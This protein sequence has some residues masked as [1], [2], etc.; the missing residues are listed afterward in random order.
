[1][2]TL[3]RFLLSFITL[4]FSAVSVYSQCV[5]TNTSSNIATAGSLKF[6]INGCAAGGTITFNIPGAGPHT[7]PVIAGAWPDG[8]L[9]IDKQLHIQGPNLNGAEIIINGQ[10]TSDAFSV[11]WWDGAPAPGANGT[12]IEGLTIVNSLVG[13]SIGPVRTDNITIRNM[14]IGV[15]NDGTVVSNKEHGII[16]NGNPTD[17]TY[18]AF[19]GAPVNN[20]KIQN[21]VISGNEKN[22]IQFGFVSNAEVSGNKIGT[23]AAGTAC[24]V[25]VGTNVVNPPGGGNGYDGILFDQTINSVVKNNVISCNGYAT[26]PNDN[27]LINGT[28]A[29]YLGKRGIYFQNSDNNTIAGNMIGTNLAGEVKLPNYKSGILISSGSDNNIIGGITATDRNIISGNGIVGGTYAAVPDKHGIVID[30]GGLGAT[31]ATGSSTKNKIIGNYIGLSTSGLPL[32]NSKN[33]VEI[34]GNGSNNLIG[35]TT[36]D[37]I[38]VISGNG[39]N[40]VSI[41]QGASSNKITGNFIGTK[42]DGTAGGAT[43]GNGNVGV[44]L[45]TGTSTAA[46]SLK[47]LTNNTIQN[48]IIGQSKVGIQT[49]GE[50][51][52]NS[53]V[54]K[55][56]LIGSD[57]N[58]LSIPN[59]TNGILIQTELTGFQLGGVLVTESNI[60]VNSTQ[61]GINIA[62]PV[63]ST[64]GAVNA[65]YNNYIGVLKNG[66]VAKNGLSGIETN[67]KAYNIIIGGTATNQSN[68][69]AGNDK[70]GVYVGGGDKITIDKNFIGLLADGLTAKGNKG[71]GVQFDGTTNAIVQNAQIAFNGTGTS[72]DGILITGATST[73]TLDKNL[74]GT[75]TAMTTNQANL[76]FGIN[77]S[78]GVG[79]VSDNSIAYNKQGGINV[80]GA[81]GLLTI[82][83]NKIGTVT[84]S[85]P[86]TGITISGGSNNQLI[87]NTV[88]NHAVDGVSIS[89]TTVN[90]VSGN[91][92]QDNTVNGVSISGGTNTFNN[93][94][95]ANTVTANKGD[96][97]NI[98]GGT[99]TISS[100]N[101]TN[102]TLNGYSI[103]D[104]VNSIVSSTISGNTKNGIVL[105]GALGKT[106]IGAGTGNSISTN[107]ENGI[108]MTNGATGNKVDNNSAINGNGTAG[109]VGTGSGI[110][111]DNASDNVIGSVANNIKNNLVHGILVINGSANN[112]IMRSRLGGNAEQGIAIISAGAGNEITS[113]TIESSGKNGL[114]I[115]STSGTIVT[116][117]N[118]GTSVSGNTLDGINLNQASGNTFTSN[119]V[120]FNNAEGVTLNASSTNTFTSNTIGSNIS[121]GV[122]ITGASNTNTFESNNIG[123]TAAGADNSNG[124]NKAGIQVNGGTGN[125]IG[126]TGKPNVFGGTTQDYGVF[127]DGGT[128]TKIDFNYFGTKNAT[129][130]DVSTAV[131]AILVTGGTAKV[132]SINENVFSY[133]TKVAVSLESTSSATSIN[134]NYFGVDKDGTTLLA[135]GIPLTAIS[136]YKGITATAVTNNIIPSTTSDAIVI[137]GVSTGNTVTGNK[138]GVKGDNTAG[139][140]SAS[141]VGVKVIG[142]T[143]ALTV[144]A[145]IIGLYHDGINLTSGTSDATISGNFIG[146]NAALATVDLGNNTTGILID[147]T[148]SN[149]ILSSNTI[150][151]NAEG[152]NV[153][154]GSGNLISQNST[155]CNG[156]TTNYGNGTGISLTGGNNNFMSGLS[157]FK[158][159]IMTK[160]GVRTLII[161]NDSLTKYGLPTLVSG[162][163]VEIFEND[164]DCQNC[165]G[166]TYSQTI[167]F[168]ATSIEIPVTI[169]TTAD[170]KKYVFTVTDASNNTSP[171]SSCSFCGGCSQPTTVDLT[172]SPNDTVCDGGDI[173][174]AVAFTPTTGYGIAWYKDNVE[175]PAQVGLSTFDNITLTAG[176]NATY[177]VRIWDNA[178]PANKAD[179]ACY[180]EVDSTL[181][182]LTLPTASIASGPAVCSGDSATLNFTFTGISPFTFT[183]TDGTT[184]VT[185]SNY[186]T[187]TYSKKVAP[188]VGTTSYS[189]SAM[190]D[191]FCTATSL[192]SAATVTVNP[193]PVITVTEP[194]PTC[195]TAIA[196]PIA[197]AGQTYDYKTFDF[198]TV[199]TSPVT[200]SGSYQII[201]TII[202]TGCKDTASILASI[203]KNPLITTT[204]ISAVCAPLQIDLATGI[205]TTST[206]GG[207][208][209][210]T[211]QVDADSKTSAL[212]SSVVSEGATPTV[213]YFVRSE[214]IYTEAASS[215]VTSTTCFVTDD[216][217]VTIN[218]KPVMVGTPITGVC[219][220]GTIDLNLGIDPTTTAGLTYSYHKI[221]F[222]T[223]T[224]VVADSNSY[225]IIGI[226]V[227]SCRDTLDV[228]ADIFSL[229]FVTASSNSPVCVGDAINL[230]STSNVSATFAWT[231]PSSYTDATQNP[232]I[233]GATLAMDGVYTIEVTNSTTSCK[234]TATTTVAVKAKPTP[235]IT[236][237][238]NECFNA[239]PAARKMST[240]N[241]SGNTYTWVLTPVTGNA[242]IVGANNSNSIDLNYLGFGTVNVEV[243]EKVGSCSEVATAVLTIQ[244]T[245]RYSLS[246]PADCEYITNY[247][248]ASHTPSSISVAGATYSS[249]NGQFLKNGSPLSSPLDLSTLTVG[250]NKIEY[251]YTLGSA[252]NSCVSKVFADLVV[253]P[254]PA[255]LVFAPPTPIC[256]TVSPITLSGT[257][258]T[259]GITASYIG[260]GVIGDKFNPSGLGGT[261]STITYTAT[262][263]ATGCF[264]TKNATIAV[265]APGDPLLAISQDS[266]RCQ[267][268]A[269]LFTVKDLASVITT[270]DIV[271][272]RLNNPSSPAIHQGLTYTAAKPTEIN[273]NDVLYVKVVPSVGSCT[274]S[275]TKTLTAFTVKVPD[276]TDVI[277]DPLKVCLGEIFTLGASATNLETSFSFDWFK[278]DLES[279]DTV[280]LSGGQNITDEGEKV[281]AF[282]YFVK[283]SNFVSTSS[284]D[285]V[286]FTSDPTNI[287]QVV[288]ASI[289]AL[290]GPSKDALLPQGSRQVQGRPIILDARHPQD[291]QQ[292][293]N[294]SWTL[295]SV[296]DR[297]VNEGAGSTKQS[298]HTPT[299]QEGDK[300]LVY[301]VSANIKDLATCSASDTVSVRL[302]GNCFVP[303]GFSPNGDGANDTWNIHCLTDGDYPDAIV[304]IYNRWGELIYKDDRGGVIPWDGTRNGNLVPIGTYYFVIDLNFEDIEQIAGAVAIMR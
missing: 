301:K 46:G 199:V 298:S 287:V 191:K 54:V 197:P 71:N 218:P 91:T 170:C 100:T 286:C 92:I 52:V 184:P 129:L 108:L 125:I 51:K 40:G 200:D 240:P 246:L 261:S 55:G 53:F 126:T 172:V 247:D 167:T 39:E 235:V 244:D 173:D 80:S 128:G 141:G 268:D 205:N 58:G 280:T 15:Q 253:N 160:S 73:F 236:N 139:A 85:S 296:E 65:I 157:A 2:N 14:K 67:D 27:T 255:G 66:T 124:A 25:T 18:A 193:L 250:V 248:L 20:L 185:I 227:N 121:N 209:Y 277:I 56:N 201:A 75:V 30:N 144:S 130:A 300:N 271:E 304:K 31:A 5:V 36:S 165:Q 35:G 176:T 194:T 187:T 29:K 59:S 76:G 206:T 82:S 273:N 22:G 239:L 293:E 143:S 155:Y 102:N 105:D 16:V 177:K 241:V 213:K 77:I 98:S 104:G 258:T 3:L 44:Q 61:S 74:I 257:S 259:A 188:A 150:A 118:I 262:V 158:P 282:K 254:K 276:I 132:A 222:T 154:L 294:Y 115:E 13:I 303:N 84:A 137:D 238:T 161:H 231:G 285:G 226:D 275:A 152:T 45:N 24:A 267:G 229:P 166:K 207:L 151:Y 252:E 263:T 195:E 68:I 279:N 265:T 284:G 70:N 17:P 292:Y 4:L 87:S 221:D 256:Q 302:I 149:N 93:S 109:V 278:V 196:L 110:V 101:V 86:K 50:A 83:T 290:A 295:V 41:G 57:K 237:V 8:P 103:S 81:D 79:T 11:G 269:V 178:D 291:G 245:A 78:G 96:G 204:P 135:A 288:D 37:S 212:V 174:L 168:S 26:N 136:L 94:T 21:S 162:Q 107:G 203:H 119:T 43:Y 99:N 249:G 211:S 220:P 230:T 116:T 145:N 114:Y 183:Y 181:Y 38:N 156:T 233:A 242:A 189:I 289:T 264:A 133:P 117:N 260:T 89:G 175:V 111:L 95:A 234:N 297:I 146:T 134:K 113:N 34:I 64:S 192:G 19:I 219:K 159:V 147:G 198:T 60:I 299:V 224:Q 148:S 1:M 270:S 171:F 243:T 12:I 210:H 33:G 32:G 214:K 97:I 123:V 163:K 47:D 223:A 88:R 28:P 153:A 10:G 127:V 62:P 6:A 112:Q 208:S 122:F 225:K 215:P 42:I 164:P 281:G 190:S 169:A 140:G 266:V 217:D 69:I 23:N 179:A 251:R 72:G 274:N 202:A 131:N 272:W 186:V 232:T 120:Q 90:L 216:I 48:N 180:K 9:G 283:V 49:I 142:N 228:Q 7:I 63:L 106:T 138:I 182:F